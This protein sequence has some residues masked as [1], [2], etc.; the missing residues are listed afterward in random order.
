M[1]DVYQEQQKI[2][3]HTLKNAIDKNRTSHAY[4][5]ETKGYP[6]RLS[7]AIAFSKSLLCP[8]HY[9]NHQNCVNCTQCDNIDKNCFSELKIIE[10]DGLWIKKEQLDELQKEFSMKSVESDKK[11]Y[12]ING[13]DRLNSSSANTI[14]KFLEEP[15]DNIVAI[16]L[17]DNAYQVLETIVSRC[18]IVSFQKQ[19]DLSNKTMIEKLKLFTNIPKEL[20]DEEKIIEKVNLIKNFVYEIEMKKLDCLLFTQRLWHEQITGKEMNLFAFDLLLL[21]VKDILNC[22]VGRTLQLFEMDD[23]LEKISNMNSLEKINRKLK[24]IIDLKEQIQYNA[25][26]S[27]L[28]D[29]LIMDLVGGIE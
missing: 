14:L 21:Y 20:E 15:E 9:T 6:D 2:V 29:R 4:L 5:F 7:L 26:A 22:K 17:A 11:V 3:Y 27:L 12:I 18:Q 16:L 8:S 25:N 28:I 1:L 24:V 19:T 13:A 10:P 23:N